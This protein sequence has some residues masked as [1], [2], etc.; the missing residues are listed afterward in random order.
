M[1]DTPH[2]AWGT[3]VLVCT[4]MHLRS[5]L[6]ACAC[7]GRQPIFSSA[8]PCQSHTCVSMRGVR[9]RQVG[10]GRASQM[11]VRHAKAGRAGGA[12][13]LKHGQ[14]VWRSQAIAGR[15][16]SRAKPDACARFSQRPPP[17]RERALKPA[18]RAGGLAGWRRRDA[19]DTH[20]RGHVV[21]QQQ[22]RDRDRAQPGEL[23]RVADHQAH[24]GRPAGRGACRARAQSGLIKQGFGRGVAA[25]GP[26]LL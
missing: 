24:R 2:Q 13:G 7:A 17:Q 18:G 8:P 3:C 25:T 6:E 26:L 15:I 12:Q 1:T 16:S 22:R 21:G 20:A 11:L 10:P 23:A 14:H 9:L 19:P 4:I 5:L